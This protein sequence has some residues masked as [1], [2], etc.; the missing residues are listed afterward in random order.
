MLSLYTNTALECRLNLLLQCQ[1]FS[2]YIFHKQVNLQFYAD[3]LSN[4]P[5]SLRVHAE[6]L[7]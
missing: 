4:I 5:L 1:I 3:H 2:I 7:C 6:S